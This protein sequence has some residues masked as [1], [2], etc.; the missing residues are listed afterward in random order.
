MEMSQNV[1]L[2]SCESI[3]MLF[4]NIDVDFYKNQVIRSYGT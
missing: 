1:A 2:G 4:L 3:F